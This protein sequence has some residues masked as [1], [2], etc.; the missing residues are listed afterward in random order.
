M[1][2]AMHPFNTLC[3]KY[4]LQMFFCS[5]NGIAINPILVIIILMFILKWLMCMTLIETDNN[6][7]YVTN[8]LV[9]VDANTVTILFTRVSQIRCRR[10]VTL[11]APELTIYY[12][13]KSHDTKVN[14]LNVYSMYYIFSCYLFISVLFI[15]LLII[16][17]G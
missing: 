10:V 4:P 8:C 3:Y 1:F 16:T 14:K 17:N 9:I 15:Y 6:C 2:L 11:S 7:L 12:Q 13:L 5:D